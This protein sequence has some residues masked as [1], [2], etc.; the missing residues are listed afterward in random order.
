MKS[1]LIFAW[2]VLLM[3]LWVHSPKATKA[4]KAELCVFPLKW[5]LLILHFHISFFILKFKLYHCTDSTFQINVCVWIFSFSSFS[6]CFLSVSITSLTQTRVTS[7]EGNTIEKMLSIKFSRV[8]VHEKY[9]VLT[10]PTTDGTTWRQ[11]DSIYT[12]ILTEHEPGNS[13]PQGEFLYGFC[14]KLLP[15]IPVWNL[16]QNALWL[17]SARCSKPFY[18]KLFL[19]WSLSQQKKAS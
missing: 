10:Q 18:P 1:S 17:N 4:Y 11:R 14:L 5:W 7:E 16:F 3:T 19:S 12:G 6:Y 9:C 2:H 13:R 8:H 15:W